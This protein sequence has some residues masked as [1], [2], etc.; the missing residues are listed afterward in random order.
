MN[1]SIPTGQL[2]DEVY[3]SAPPALK[4]QMLAQLVGQVY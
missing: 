4:K 3:E 1:P 2:V